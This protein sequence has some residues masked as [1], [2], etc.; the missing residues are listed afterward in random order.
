MSKR[1]RKKAMRRAYLKKN[2]AKFETN[3]DR[4]LADTI[5]IGRQFNPT[6]KEPV[7]KVTDYSIIN[8]KTGEIEHRL[9]SS[10]TDPMMAKRNI[11]EQT[12]EYRYT[13]INTPLRKVTMF[14]SGFTHHEKYWF[15]WFDPITEI[16]RESITYGSRV[17]AMS[18][19]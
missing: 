13:L 8:G 2:T 10:E 14:I 12:V 5:G 18:Y 3:P 19:F 4:V 11:K 17:I 16:E 6:K 15:K 9:T 1:P 7:R